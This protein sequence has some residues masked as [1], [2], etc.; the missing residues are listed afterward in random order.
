VCA[1][2][3]IFVNHRLRRQDLPCVS[4]TFPEE[5]LLILPSERW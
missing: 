1:V 3:S 4:S 2:W 5:L